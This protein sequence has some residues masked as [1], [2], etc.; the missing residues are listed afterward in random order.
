MTFDAEFWKWVELNSGQDTTGLRLKGGREQWINQAI[1][2][3]DCRRRAST[4]IAEELK[5]PTFF[6]PTE[7]SAEQCTSDAVA[8]LH[9]SL[10]N[11]GEMV[12]DLTAGL[13][14]DAF[15]IASKAAS[16]T[17]VDIN[18]EVASALEHNAK[19]LGLDNVSAVC[20][21][22]REYIATLPDCA[23]D[24]VFI[25]PARRSAD[26]RRLFSL[27]DCQPDVVELL[28]Q[29]ARVARRLIVKASP[30]LDITA[31][32]RD[33]SGT[34]A[35]YAAGTHTECKELLVVVDLKNHETPEPVIHVWTSDCDYRFTQRQEAEA[36]AAY[37]VPQKGWWLYEP[38]AVTQKAAPYRLLS[39]EFGLMKLAANTHLYTSPDKVDGFPGARRRVVDV[40]PFA[41]RVLKTF[42]RTYPRMDV[43]VRN[44]P[45]SAD[46]L[47]AKL[48][49]GPASVDGFRLMGATTQSGEKMLIVLQ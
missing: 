2:Q 21:D 12:L 39:S 38:W 37:G 44:F 25:D 30:M 36:T 35:V 43:A 8:S 20:A 19:A 7:L 28:P 16:V 27:H 4:K 34:V 17:A 15:H 23:F 46:A 49:V 24:T 6:F 47:R 33:L 9:A 45:L 10:V 31:T 40:L 48:H 5:C 26:N 1:M 41:S 32:I 18:A 22:C 14:I 11:P 13:G 42:A 29:I 3:I